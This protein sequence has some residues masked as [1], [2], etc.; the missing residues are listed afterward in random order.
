MRLAVV[1]DTVRAGNTALDDGDDDTAH[2]AAAAVV[3]MT[4]VLGVN[5][6]SPVWDN[7]GPGGADDALA[8]LDVLVTDQLAARQ[9][10]APAREFEAADAIR[11]RLAQAGIVIND[12]PSGARWSFADGTV[13]D[14]PATP[15]REQCA[16][17]QGSDRRVRGPTPKKP[18]GQ[19]ADAKAAERET[20]PPPRRP[21]RPPSGPGPTTPRVCRGRVRTSS[22]ARV[23]AAGGGGGKA[24]SEIVAGR[25]AIVKRL[26][27][28]SPSRRCT[29]PADDAD[30]R[31]RTPSRPP[32][33]ATSPCSTP[34]ASWT[35]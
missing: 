28:T 4:E 20:T 27:P 14:I 31:V 5:P 25:N 33:D 1:H 16:V 8:A 22:G 30:D 29:S 6:L 10:A 3:A 34:V 35:G 7:S 26:R 21:A 12:T 11:D 19:G 15:A 32:P 13:A 24:S 2:E 17:G 18:R 9:S 23:G